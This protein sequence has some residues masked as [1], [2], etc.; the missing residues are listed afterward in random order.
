[1]DG[2]GELSRRRDRA[3]RWAPVAMLGLVLLAAAPGQAWAQG[4][5]A[6]LAGETN[7]CPGCDLSNQLLK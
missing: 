1:M 2:T 6:L 4:V 7:D 3:W 5:D